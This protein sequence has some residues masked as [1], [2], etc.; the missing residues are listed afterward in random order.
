[1]HYMV[2]FGFLAYS[3]CL[4]CAI[5]RVT[6]HYCTPVPG[7]GTGWQCCERLTGLDLD[8]D[9]VIGGRVEEREKNVQDAKENAFKHHR[10]FTSFLLEETEVT[11]SKKKGKK[12]SRHDQQQ[13][14]IFA[15]EDAVKEN[16][17]EMTD[18]L[19]RKAQVEHGNGSQFSFANPSHQQDTIIKT[20][21][22][23]GQ[24]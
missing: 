8:G 9:G 22:G 4:F 2:G 21:G 7:G 13:E 6:C 19:V 11:L 17:L 20:K 16:S 3:F 15:F 14:D 24:V 5:I 1:M 18:G 23:S 10:R 12:Q